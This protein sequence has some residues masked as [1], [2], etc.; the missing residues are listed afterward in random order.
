MDVKSQTQQLR[1]TTSAGKQ[2]YFDITGP[3]PALK[4]EYL[5]EDAPRLLPVTV[6]RMEPKQFWLTVRVP[7]DASPGV[8][9]STIHVEPENAPAGALPVTL[10]VLPFKLP[11]PSLEYSNWY[12]AGL[13]D[14][15]TPLISAALKTE[16]QL[17]AEFRDMKAHGVTNPN[18]HDRENIEEYLRIR[19]A[20]GMDQERVFFGH[21]PGSSTDE[22]LRA[23]MAMFRGLGFKDVYLFGIDEAT[24]QRLSG[25]RP[26]WQRARRLG[27]K[28]YASCYV[29]FFPLVG[30]ILDAPILS[31][32][33]RPDLA[34]KVK[35]NGF[36]IYMYNNPQFGQPNPE[37]YRRNYGLALW[38]AGYNGAMGYAYQHNQVHHMWNDM[39][40]G[41]L[42]KMTY[43]TSNG[44]VATMAWEGFREGVDDVRYVTL[45]ESLLEEAMEVAAARDQ[46][47]RVRAWLDELDVQRD[48][49]DVRAE[50]C[51]RIAAISKALDQPGDED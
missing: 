14:D 12:A 45:L 20:V 44:V 47:M 40:L 37:T 34:A 13:K 21:G 36:R 32:P 30:D 23:R 16:Q 2:E 43:P 22:Q 49:D 3:N 17:A 42:D 19:N 24:D 18:V 26:D 46:A 15:D 50:L 35:A 33:G 31:G 11:R 6:R 4:N 7:P 27:F 51:E 38:Q 41:I 39:A 9:R 25:Q 28:I 5:I 8:Y 29:D 10:N 1:V 48:L